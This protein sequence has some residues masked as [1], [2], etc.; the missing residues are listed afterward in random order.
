M[1]IALKPPKKFRIMAVNSI[2]IIIFLIFVYLINIS[3]CSA[4]SDIVYSGAKIMRLN[5]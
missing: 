4:Y 1:H 2:R 5:R 3:Y